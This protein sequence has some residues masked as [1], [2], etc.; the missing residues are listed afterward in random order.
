[1]AF[2]AALGALLTNATF[3]EFALPAILGAGGS[4]FGAGQERRATD[5][6]RRR[7]EE[8]AR[9]QAANLEPFIEQLIAMGNQIQGGGDY[10]GMRGTAMRQLDLGSQALNAQLAQRGVY[11][12]GAALG[13]QRQLTGDVMSQLSQA[14]AQDQ[15]MRQQAASQ[16]YGQAAGIAGG[17]P[18]LGYGSYNFS[19][20]GSLPPLPS[21]TR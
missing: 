1:M 12:S 13:A 19:G 4:L 20:L 10:G 9:R 6:Q 21:Y 8:A 2:P 16:L 17:L 18:G 11:S 14:I 5:R 3:L 7:D 15:L